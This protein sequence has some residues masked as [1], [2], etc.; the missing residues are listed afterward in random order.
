MPVGTSPDWELMVIPY[1][2]A[3]SGVRG[4]PLIRIS[5]AESGWAFASSCACRGVD[6]TRK[7]APSAE[8]DTVYL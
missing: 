1:S 4:M 3:F 6:S 5:D 8:M 7:P 2:A